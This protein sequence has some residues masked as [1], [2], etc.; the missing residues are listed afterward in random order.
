MIIAYITGQY[1]RASDTFI[2]NEVI[3]LRR[4]GHQVH[5]FS[6]RRDPSSK[7]LDAEVQQEQANTTYVLEQGALSLISAL[8]WAVTTRPRAF[9]ASARLAWSTRAEGLK[10]AVMQFVY[11]TEATYVARDLKR[12]KVQIL[13]NHIAENSATVA[14]LAACIAGIPFSMTV[15]GP[16]IFFHPHRWAL[17]T[18]VAR[19]AFTA[20][21]THF[22]RSQCMLFSEPQHW[23]RIHVVRCTTSPAFEAHTPTPAKPASH[24]LFVGRLCAE[25]GLL[26]LIDALIMAKASGQDVRL[27]VIGDGPLKHQCQQRLQQAGCAEAVQWLGWRSSQDII[28][29]LDACRA[30]VLPSFAEGLPVA[31]MEA[32]MMGRP[33]ITTQIA[34]IPELVSNDT[35]GWLVAPGCVASLAKALS[36]A[37]QLPERDLTTMGMAAREAAMKAHHHETELKKLEQLLTVHAAKGQGHAHHST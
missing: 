34:G 11:L 6:I 8:G 26:V 16:G 9:M 37:W 21:I 13:H 29:A 10:A 33:V 36:T 27:S 32:F 31:I 7:G 30:L 1:A 14:M 12:H 22:C 17:G 18:K 3:G 23:S 24:F 15:H 25:K 5:T 4:L 20:A 28:Q 19:A 35:N 2:R